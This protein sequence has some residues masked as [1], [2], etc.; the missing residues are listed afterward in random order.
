MSLTT[1]STLITGVSA[2]GSIPAGAIPPGA[3]ILSVADIDDPSPELS[4]LGAS[5]SGILL[6]AIQEPDSPGGHMPFTIYVWNEMPLVSPSASAYGSAYD[7]E[8]IPYLIDSLE[9]GQWVA[10]GGKYS[11][12]ETSNPNSGG[13][14]GAEDAWPIG[15]V[16]LAVVATDPATLLGFG[17]WERI[18]EGQLLAGYKSGDA[19]FGTVEG[20]GGA[21]TT[22]V[23]AHA[24]H[25]HAVDVGL[26]TTSQPSATVTAS[27]SGTGVHPGSETHTHTVDP[28]SVTSG[29]P[30]ASLTHAAASILPPYV[31]VYVWKRTA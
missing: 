31:V 12:Q 23:D 8:N 21:K 17:T 6:V 26:T 16:F 10:A 30:S 5:F 1:F 28:V 20:T 2:Y 25:T 14:G 24:A 7:E 19:D 4:Q 29:N 11:Y 15:S 18:A 13:G 9:G 3:M 27:R 22:T